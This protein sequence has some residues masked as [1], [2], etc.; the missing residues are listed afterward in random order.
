[1]TDQ[2]L[3]A[4]KACEIDKEEEEREIFLNTNIISLSNESLCVRVIRKKYKCIM[5]LLLILLIT[6]Q[7][8][9]TILT[10]INEENLNMYLK[11]IYHATTPPVETNIS[12]FISHEYD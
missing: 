11:K 4:K 3:T 6:L 8:I 7:I 10:N 5:L 2:K 9:K 1:M 12:N